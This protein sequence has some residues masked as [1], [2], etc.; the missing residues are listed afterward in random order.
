MIF[1]SH[2]C[3][4]FHVGKA[5]GTS[6]EL[7]F[8]PRR[9]QA[10]VANRETFFGLDKELKI[11]LQHATPTIMREHIPRDVFDSYYKFCVV[12]NPFSR[13]VS[14]Y[15][16]NAHLAK[17]YGCFEAFVLG[18]KT[19][20]D[21]DDP[22]L[23]SHQSAQYCYTQIEGRNV[24]DSVLHLERLP[25]AFNKVRRATKLNRPLAWVNRSKNTDWSTKPTHQHYSREMQLA[26]LETYA[27][28][29]ELFGYQESPKTLAP[30]QQWF[31]QA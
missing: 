11:Y 4:F 18:L 31:W 5:A 1:H 7:A 2:R 9:R 30:K 29:F 15:Q 17:R 6:V 21:V 3:I 14:V 8:D 24:C 25:R 16:Y 20:F 23:C 10:N 27:R 26:L 22:H 19:D 12:R 28:D 13:L